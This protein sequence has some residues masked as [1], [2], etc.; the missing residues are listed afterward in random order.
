MIVVI[1]EGE[2]TM[3]ICLCQAVTDGQIRK[4][5]EQDATVRMRDL[6]QKLGICGNCG[7]CGPQALML[8]RDGN[9]INYR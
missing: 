7:K 9:K 3:Y 5:I 1:A 8:L 6:R 2:Q 4:A